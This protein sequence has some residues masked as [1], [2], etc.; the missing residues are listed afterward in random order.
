MPVSEDDLAA[1]IASLTDILQHTG[2]A[3]GS[4]EQV[5]EEWEINP[6]LLARNFE[7]KTGRSVADYAGIFGPDGLHR[8]ALFIANGFSF[9]LNADKKTVMTPQGPLELHKKVVTDRFGRRIML[10]SISEGLIQ[11]AEFG[12]DRAREANLE[13]RFESRDA[14]I[15]ALRKAE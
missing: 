3:E 11:F 14:L 5:A 13:E 9:G 15:E 12:E 8:R 10:I 7:R 4:V 6:D 2:R 1:A